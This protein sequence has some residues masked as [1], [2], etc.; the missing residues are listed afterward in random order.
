MEDSLVRA[1]QSRGPTVRR[2]PLPTRTR[3]PCR[4]RIHDLQIARFKTAPNR[5][6][7]HGPPRHDVSVNFDVPV[8]VEREPT[9]T[10]YFVVVQSRIACKVDGEIMLGPQP[11]ELCS[12]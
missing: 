10:R 6:H 7:P 4:Y 12:A 11:G 1:P 8:A 3:V 5:D 9:V 2:L